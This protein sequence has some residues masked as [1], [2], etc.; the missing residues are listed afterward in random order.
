[1][2]KIAGALTVSLFVSGLCVPLA[3]QWLDYPTPGI[4]RTPDG[5]PNLAAPTP[6]AADGKP[7]LSGVWSGPGGGSYDRNVARDLSAKDIQP[8]AEALYQ[9]RVRDMGKDAPRATCLPD[10]FPYY[11][12]VDLARFVQTPS[13]IVVLYQGTTNSVHRTIFTDGRPLP[14][15]PNP[16]WMGYSVGHWEGDTLVVDTAG[17]NDRG[18][19]DIEGHPHTEAL[20]ITERFRR[21]DL[22]H[23]D[24]EMTIDDPKTFT[25][26]FTLKIPKTLR[27]DTDLLESVCENDRSVPHMLGGVTVTKLAPDILSKYAGTYE[28]APGR[29]AVITIEADLLFIREGSNPLKLPL[30]ANS[31]TVFV[32]RTN[33]DWIEFTRDARGVASGFVYH[34]GAGDRKAVRKQ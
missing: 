1:M 25:R 16:T 18:W 5:K 13:L 7:D 9:Q 28:F 34:T 17:F 3:A 14:A 11:H 15:D 20:H 6:R 4:P 26:P 27:P 21:R 31:E 33:G 8:W 30:V 24:L 22:G 32:S 2:N 10:P 29:E 23:M 12:M 19:L